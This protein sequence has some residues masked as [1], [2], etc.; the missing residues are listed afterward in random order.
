MRRAF[1]PRTVV[2][3]AFLVAVPIAALAL[4]AGWLGIVLA[5]V[6][7]YLLVLVVEGSLTRRERPARP[8]LDAEPAPLALDAD[9]GSAVEAVGPVTP[10]EPR[11]DA[12]APKS[13]PA[14]T[15]DAAPAPEPEPEAAAESAAEPEARPERPESDAAEPAADEAEPEPSAPPAEAEP[16]RER[17]PE[18]VPVAVAAR[19]ADAPAEPAAEAEPPADVVALEVAPAPR[20]WNV[21]DLERLARERSGVDPARDEE[22]TFLLLYLRE[23]ADASGLLPVDF[24]G[25]VRESFGDLVGAV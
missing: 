25:L 3:A 23:F 19:E 11:R 9:P 4:G 12:E 10:V 13:A 6:V 22:R 16:A 7:A 8:R 14:Q 20:R 18:A 2:E 24:D 17:E 5:S 1:G 21:W 15:A